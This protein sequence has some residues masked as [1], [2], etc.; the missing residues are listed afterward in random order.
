MFIDPKLPNEIQQFREET[1]AFIASQPE[2]TVI[3]KLKYLNERKKAED[4]LWKSIG[5]Q[6][7]NPN[8]R[9]TISDEVN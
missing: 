1:N 5:I 7:T 6:P 2:L 8:F 9:V 3:D 4:A